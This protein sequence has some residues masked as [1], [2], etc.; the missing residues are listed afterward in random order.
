MTRML[1]RRY[2]TRIDLLAAMLRAC[3]TLEGWEI[4]RIYWIG[5]PPQSPLI[6]WFAPPSLNFNRPS[7]PLLQSLKLLKVRLIDEIVYGR[8]RSIC[9]I[10]KAA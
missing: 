3:R 7:Y 9:I 2:R 10:N 5:R 1:V 8:S 4:D 6:E